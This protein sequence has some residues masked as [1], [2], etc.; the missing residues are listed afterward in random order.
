MEAHKTPTAPV[1]VAGVAVEV[2]GS[3]RTEV[4]TRQTTMVQLPGVRPT[5]M[6][7]ATASRITGVAEE[8]VAVVVAAVA[9]TIT[10]R[11]PSAFS[12]VPDG[13]IDNPTITMR[14]DVAIPVQRVAVVIP[15][16]LLTVEITGATAREHTGMIHVK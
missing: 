12:P 6:T 8:L 3:D 10:S 4:S 2:A 5:Q 7:V 15:T 9:I 16:R 14:V 13:V 1:R 11:H